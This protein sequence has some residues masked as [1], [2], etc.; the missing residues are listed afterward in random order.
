VAVIAF[1]LGGVTGTMAF[2]VSWLFL[3]ADVWTATK[4]YF[5]IAL[6]TVVLL[7]LYRVILIRKA[8]QSTDR[9]HRHP[10]E[11]GARNSKLHM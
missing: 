5:S 3:G 6:L 1:V 11:D 10:I 9:T 7:M 2:A 4:L 8:R